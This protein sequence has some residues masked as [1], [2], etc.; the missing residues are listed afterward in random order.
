MLSSNQSPE[1]RLTFGADVGLCT[2]YVIVAMAFLSVRVSD[3]VR[4]RVKAIAAAR[5]EKLQDLVGGLIEQF[6]Q[7][8]DRR[9]PQLADVLRRLREREPELRA[10]GVAAL[11]VFGS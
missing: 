9:P 7:E 5:G 1:E 8:T 4:N 2:K 6:L 3:E 10:R 11:W